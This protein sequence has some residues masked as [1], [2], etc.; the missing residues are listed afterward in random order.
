[1]LKFL[2]F[3]DFP[4]ALSLLHPNWPENLFGKVYFLQP[5]FLVIPIL[6]FS[7]LLYR[8]KKIRFFSLLAL[9]G[10]FFAKGINEPLGGIFQWMFVHIPGFVMFRDP[11]KFYLYTAIGYSVLIPTVLRKLNK[12][13]VYVLFVLFWFFT[14]RG[15]QVRTM[16]LPQEYMQLKNILVSDAIPSRT[17]WIPA[18][19][20]F[21][22]FSDTHPLLTSTESAS[23]DPSVK[24]IIVPMDV[25]KKIFL[26]DYTFDPS[27]REKVIAGI[28]LSRDPRFNDLAVFEN[29]AY[30]GMHIE[31][32]P[33]VVS[34]QN[35]ANIGLGI[36]V[37]FLLGWFVWLYFTR[38]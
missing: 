11:T 31:I 32:P 4:H 34:Q 14:L 8:E 16:Q 1:M 20:N 23:V 2:S 26:N 33:I 36:S 6:A 21:A 35:L 24:Y 18:K 9:I 28:H 38:L 25:G 13:F 17:L 5:E 12:K 29:P 37:A 30:S 15:F 3:A 7:A 22:Y 19:E 10:V 27:L